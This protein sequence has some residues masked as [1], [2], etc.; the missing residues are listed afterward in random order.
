MVS[1]K[2][3]LVLMLTA[4]GAMGRSSSSFR[5][6]DRRQGFGNNG[7]DPLNHPAAPG[8]GG[9]G[10]GGGGFGNNGADPLNHPA[11]PGSQLVA[12]SAGGQQHWS[13]DVSGMTGAELKKNLPSGFFLGSSVD[14]PDLKDPLVAPLVK[15]MPWV[16]PGNSL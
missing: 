9:G 13:T 5:R 7:A 3:A 11:G 4:G 6:L 14:N 2:L 8:G 1:S 16:T 15:Y 12:A 10:G